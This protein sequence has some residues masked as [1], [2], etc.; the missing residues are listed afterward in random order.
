MNFLNY[1]LSD[2]VVPGLNWGIFIENGILGEAVTD[3]SPQPIPV[4]QDSLTNIYYSLSIFEG[5]FSESSSSATNTVDV[6]LYDTVLDVYG[7]LG[8]YDGILYY[9]VVPQPVTSGGG[10]G[11]LPW[12]YYNYL[13]NEYNV[14]EVFYSIGQKSFRRK[15]TVET[16]GAKSFK[17][18]NNYKAFGQKKFTRRGV[19]EG[20]GS[21]KFTR[22]GILEGAGTKVFKRGGILEGLGSKK[23]LRES[24]L[25]GEGFKCIRSREEIFEGKG[26]RGMMRILTAL[27]IL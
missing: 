7:Q 24:V 21:K 4:I 18:S 27:D 14:E 20:L 15:L 2:T 6:V 25:R 26:K 23:Y 22:D 3:E 11:P 16:A 9:Y 19:V 12:N 1:I 10:A 5:I 17:R 8:M 13:Y